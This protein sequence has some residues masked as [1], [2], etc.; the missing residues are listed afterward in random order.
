MA[1]LTD[2]VSKIEFTDTDPFTASTDPFDGTNEVLVESITDGGDR[3]TSEPVMVARLDN[4]EGQASDTIS[5]QYHVIKDDT[6]NTV[7]DNLIEF[8]NSSTRVWVKETLRPL[9]PGGSE[10]VQIIGGTAGMGM[11][12]GEQSQGIGQYQVFNVMLNATEA[13]AGLLIDDEPTYT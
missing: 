12:I 9:T 7:I 3:P 13:T 8:V 11:A 10:V 6:D 1:N 4:V 5:L 2:L